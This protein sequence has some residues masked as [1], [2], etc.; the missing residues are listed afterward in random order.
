[1]NTLT[2]RLSLFLFTLLCFA[3]R[4]LS[5]EVRGHY[6]SVSQNTHLL[7]Q[8]KKKKKISH[9][10]SHVKCLAHTIFY[11]FLTSSPGPSTYCCII[12]KCYPSNF[13]KHQ[14]QQG[15]TLWIHMI[16]YLNTMHAHT[17]THKEWVMQWW[18]GSLFRMNPLTHSSCPGAHSLL[19]GSDRF[20]FQ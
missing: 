1:M 4:C 7:T 3:Q 2:V 12:V 14:I 19:S 13:N 11:I 20:P 10:A 16:G 18:K 6:T 8:K 15:N 5:G 17:Q 9:N